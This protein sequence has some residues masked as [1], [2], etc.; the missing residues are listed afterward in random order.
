MAFVTGPYCFMCTAIAPPSTIYHRT[1]YH[2]PSDP[3]PDQPTP[4]IVYEEVLPPGCEKT[5][6]PLTGAQ[7]EY[8]NKQINVRPERLMSCLCDVQN[9]LVI[10]QRTRKRVTHCLDVLTARTAC[11][12]LLVAE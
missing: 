11:T 6:M 9:A 7:Q 8:L 3:T 2:L 5:T 1:I 10:I 12:A 4:P